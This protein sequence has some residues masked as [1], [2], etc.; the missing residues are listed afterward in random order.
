MRGT[1]SPTRAENEQSIEGRTDSFISDLFLQSPYFQLSPE[2]GLSIGIQAAGT[3]QDST[4]EN[5]LL[6]C[7]EKVFDR[8]KDF[9]TK[10]KYL[11][12]RLND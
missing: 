11:V 8:V 6:S 4:M 7:A 2:V 9:T 1:T 10:R 3:V 12:L 5:E